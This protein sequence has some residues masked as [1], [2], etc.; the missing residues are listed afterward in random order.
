[1]LNIC[2]I[3]ALFNVFGY[4]KVLLFW[5]DTY[6]KIK[7]SFQRQIIRMIYLSISCKG[8]TM[9]C[10]SSV[11]EL[12]DLFQKSISGNTSLRT[13]LLK[14]NIENYFFLIEQH[15]QEKGKPIFL[16]STC[17]VFI[18]ISTWNFISA[19]TKIALA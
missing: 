19:F 17:R 1:M 12:N 3:I 18:I 8:I 4:S 13:S 14:M 6:F 11:G 16:G 10:G 9:T 2:V 15:P 5:V 7:F